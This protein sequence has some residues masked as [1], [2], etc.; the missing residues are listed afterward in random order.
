M[1]TTARVATATHTREERQ[2]VRFIVPVLRF[3]VTGDGISLIPV[4]I[5]R[6]ETGKVYR[7]S[8]P[9]ASCNRDPH[10][11]HRVF[12]FLTDSDGSGALS[13]NDGI[14]GE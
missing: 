1:A 8:P 5:R 10:S 11:G 4:L 3:A 12:V 2:K 9:D 7:I 13:V 6:T 14:C